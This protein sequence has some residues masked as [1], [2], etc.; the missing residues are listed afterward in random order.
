LWTNTY[1][2]SGSSLSLAHCQPFCFSSLCLLKVCTELSSLPPPTLFCMLRAPRP[3]CCV[4]LFSSLFIIQFF[5]LWG[6]VQSVQGAMLVYP[7]GGCGNAMCHLFAHLL[8]CVSQAGLELASG[9]TGALLF[10]QWNV[11]WRSFV[12]ASGS[13][14]WIF[15]SSWWFFSAKCGSRMLAKF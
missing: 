2:I 10:S 3:L 6:G 11:M 8:V 15:Y 7:R 13:E 14:C 12:R 5:F 1:P 9:I 4:F